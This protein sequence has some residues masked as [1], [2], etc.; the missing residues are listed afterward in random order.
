MPFV[1]ADDGLVA[2]PYFTS[3]VAAVAGEKKT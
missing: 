1:V 3:N 2:L